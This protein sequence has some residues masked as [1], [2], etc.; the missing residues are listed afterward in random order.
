MSMHHV[1][2]QR[3]CDAIRCS[4]AAI[5]R[6]YCA[7]RGTSNFATFSTAETYASSAVIAAT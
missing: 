2:S 6:R 7:R 5:T 4:S 3:Q 1:P